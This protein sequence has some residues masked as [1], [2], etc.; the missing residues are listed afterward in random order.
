MKMTAQVE[1]VPGNSKVVGIAT[2]MLDDQLV[3]DGFKVIN[4]EKGQ[5]VAAPSV[6]YADKSTGEMKYQEICRYTSLDFRQKLE[7]V[8]IQAYRMAAAT[9]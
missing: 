9:K 4:G 5:F 1:L 3:I 8:I 2:I 6:S 7:R